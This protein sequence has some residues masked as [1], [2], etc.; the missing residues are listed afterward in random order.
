MVSVAEIMMAALAE[1]PRPERQRGRAKWFYASLPWRRLRY[2]VLAENPK[3][4]GGVARC[5]LCGTP[6]GV[7]APLNVDHIE[8]LSRCW[9]RRLD[10]TNLQLLCGACN[11]RK[12]NGT[13]QDFRPTAS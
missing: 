7:C 13:A 4:K 6:A 11:H 8:T 2:A 12:L 1:P 3:R 10:W 9:S 5:E